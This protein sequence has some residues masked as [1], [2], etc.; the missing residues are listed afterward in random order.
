MIEK[1][2]II[3]LISYTAKEGILRHQTPTFLLSN[4][5]ECKGEYSEFPSKYSNFYL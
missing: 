3:N 5:G 4:L 1:D 2:N